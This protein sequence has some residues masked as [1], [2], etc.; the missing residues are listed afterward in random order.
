M[1]SSSIAK[2]G[3]NK[4]KLITFQLKSQNEHLNEARKLCVFKNIKSERCTQIKNFEASNT[5]DIK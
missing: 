4:V 2:T 1:E 3:I 5:Q